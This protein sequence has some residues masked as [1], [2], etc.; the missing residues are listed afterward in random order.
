MVVRSLNAS[1]A[2][3]RLPSETVIATNLTLNHVEDE[4]IPLPTSSSDAGLS[5]VLLTLVAMG[6]GVLTVRFVTRGKK[7]SSN[8]NVKPPFAVLRANGQQN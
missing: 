5:M 7:E 3:V 6:A 2:A 8:E 1:P 4:P